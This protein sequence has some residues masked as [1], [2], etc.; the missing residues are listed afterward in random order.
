[1]IFTGTFT[2]K[3]DAK[4]RVFLPSDLRKQLAESDGRL[5]IKR[6]LYQPCL[7]IYPYGVW[8]QEVDRLRCRLN[9]WDPRHAMI[10]R[11]FLADAEVFK[12]DGNGRL[13]LNGRNRRHCRLSEQVSGAALSFIGV[14]DRI[15]IW[16]EAETSKAFLA[17]EDFAAA[18]SDLMGGPYN[19]LFPSETPS[20]T[21]T[22]HSDSNE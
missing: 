1:M 14:D 5:V 15:E 18:M 4:G 9:R 20:A 8:E 6:D 16:S 10:F 11:Q 2:A 17:A 7:T 12:L 3:L 22:T 19:Q 21:P 13:L